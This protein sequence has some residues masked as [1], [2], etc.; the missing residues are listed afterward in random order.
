MK[1]SSDIGPQV[2]PSGFGPDAGKKS[3]NDDGPQI[4]GGPNVGGNVFTRPGQFGGVTRVSL[5]AR[6][7]FFPS[8]T[9]VPGQAT[10]QQ[11][12]SYQGGP[13][14]RVNR[15]GVRSGWTW[16]NGL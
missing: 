10:Y 2:L 4:N 16:G 6:L 14:G 3:G 7:G 11:V 12:D 8:A 1:I 5:P 15:Y 13:A 9:G